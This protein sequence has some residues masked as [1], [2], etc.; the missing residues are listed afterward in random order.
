MGGEGDSRE[1]RPRQVPQVWAISS[2][3]GA[4]MGRLPPLDGAA[5]QI[6]IHLAGRTMKRENCIGPPSPLVRACVT[7]A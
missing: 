5:C 1:T 7:P 2:S 3:M 6:H 4:G